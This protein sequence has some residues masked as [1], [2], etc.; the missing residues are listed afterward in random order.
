MVAW[1]P[2]GA[3]DREESVESEPVTVAGG[4]GTLDHITQLC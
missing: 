3:C 2:I 4:L 1:H